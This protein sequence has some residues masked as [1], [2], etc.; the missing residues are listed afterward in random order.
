MVSRPL[1]EAVE[2][3]I[4]STPGAGGSWQAV[5]ALNLAASIDG[6]GSLASKTAASKQLIAAMAL[7]GAGEKDASAG[8]ALDHLAVRRSERRAS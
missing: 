4:A 2:R 7:I 3:A 8:D 1:V 6:D 5:L